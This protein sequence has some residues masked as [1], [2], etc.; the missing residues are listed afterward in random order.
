VQTGL[1]TFT[2]PG[3]AAC[4]LG[5][6]SLTV[7]FRASR[8]HGIPPREPAA[9]TFALAAPGPAPLRADALDS[10]PRL[11]DIGCHDNQ[12]GWQPGGLGACTAR[13]AQMDH[14]RD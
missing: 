11:R 6:V 8:L 9:Y 1:G 5:T 14:F 4:R 3:R 12:G 13:R 10:P 7:T 2:L